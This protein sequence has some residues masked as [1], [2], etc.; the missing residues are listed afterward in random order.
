MVHL[1]YFM[2]FM[3]Y[4]DRNNVAG[5]R[6]FYVNAHIYNAKGFQGFS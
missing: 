4:I 6:L 3:D 5:A 2:M 1:F